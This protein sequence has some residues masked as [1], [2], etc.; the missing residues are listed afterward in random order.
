MA[1]AS[2]S[3]GSSSTIATAPT[4]FR[5][6]SRGN[7]VAI[8]QKRLNELGYNVGA[9]DGIYGKNTAAQVTAFQRANGLTADGILGAQTIAAMINKNTTG[10]T[11]QA[12]AVQQATIANNS[13]MSGSYPAQGAINPELA[14]GT[15]SYQQ[16]TPAQSAQITPPSGQQLG[17]DAMRMANPELNAMYA[18]NPNTVNEIAGQ[19]ATPQSNL[20]SNPPIQTGSSALGVAGG[21]NLPSGQATSQTPVQT[22]NYKG[23]GHS[24]DTPNEPTSTVP[25]TGTRNSGLGGS[26]GSGLAITSA[27]V[28]TIGAT[29]ANGEATMSPELAQSIATGTSLV[30]Q[31]NELYTELNTMSPEWNSDEDK[32]YQRD[33]VKLE[34]KVAQ[35]M[36]ARGGLYSSVARAALSSS[37][38]DL[39]LGYRKQAYE[40]F[41][42]NRDF[43]FKQLQFVSSRIDAEFDK[44]MSVKNY[45]LAVQKEQFNQK[46]QIAEFKAAQAARA[47]SQRIQQA[48]LK[49]SQDRAAAEQQLAFASQQQQATYNGLKQDQATLKIQQAQ[50]DQYKT[51]YANSNYLSNEAA[52]YLGVDSNE[53]FMGSMQALAKAQY[54]I[55]TKYA[56]LQSRTLSFGDSQTTLEIYSG[57]L[58]K[59]SS[60]DEISETYDI[61]SEDGLTKIGSRTIKRGG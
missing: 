49:A 9:T 13:A 10:E 44:A 59:N 55:D 48:Q 3:T 1:I 8:Y 12:Q 6:G 22:V 52:A 7:E 38:I 46:M 39:E 20:P 29:S 60:P 15:P 40:R 36:V 14:T 61:F 54:A 35:M 5:I 53:G 34:N 16:M 28:T 24:L 32:D 11:A 51:Q 42:T 56:D 2:E 17:A 27:P 45:E 41:I 57:V 58:P 19:M 50:L 21:G 37:M 30:N 47:A 4:L 43:V 33:A 25:V 23:L 26:S 31:A 18:T